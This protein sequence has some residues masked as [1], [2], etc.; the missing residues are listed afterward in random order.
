MRYETKNYELQVPSDYFNY[1]DFC[2]RV[3]IYKL[4][5]DEWNQTI[6]NFW[7]DDFNDDLEK[8]FIKYFR[9]ISKDY[10]D[11][12]LYTFSKEKGSKIPY[13]SRV[14]ENDELLNIE[15]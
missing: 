6:E 3:G 12:N 13:G 7:D 14:E 2:D 1:E 10:V 4:T 15:I 5:K 9:K 8:L 11:T